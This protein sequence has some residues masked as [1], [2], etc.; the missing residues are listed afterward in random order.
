MQPFS[1]L[2][3]LIIRNYDTRAKQEPDS[4][5]IKQREQIERYLPLNAERAKD[6]LNEWEGFVL[7]CLRRMRIADEEDVLYRVFFRALDA[8]PNFRG[9]SKISTWLYRIA[10]NHCITQARHRPP[11][12]HL[13][14]DDK[15]TDSNNLKQMHVTE[16]QFG[17]LLR[18]EEK[19]RM[20]EAVLHLQP[21]QQ[22][23]IELKFFQE[24]TFDEI[25]AILST[26]VST[27]KSRLYSG[28]IDGCD[29]VPR[30]RYGCIYE[31]PY[32]GG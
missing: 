14:I 6:F 22:A 25:A 9:D 19:S 21:E 13:S 27:I 32:E 2:V 20:L 30:L 4:L 24:L 16:T 3:V 18:S 28:F 8:L 15:R 11:G 29:E 7:S 1:T 12:I 5:M 10:L 23:V 17:R 26:P 31:K